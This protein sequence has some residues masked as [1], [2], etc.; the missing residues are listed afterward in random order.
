MWACGSNGG[1]NNNQSNSPL[2]YT[3]KVSPDMNA[4]VVV[5]V[6]EVIE[7][8]IVNVYEIND[9][10]DKINMTES[11]VRIGESITFTAG[12]NV[13]KIKVHIGYAQ[14]FDWVE[15]WIPIT[16]ILQPNQP[17]EILIKNFM[18]LS[19]SEP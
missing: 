2:Q 14:G 15:G 9:D 7:G 16:Y 18:T 12:Q 17:R 8:V 11:V 5:P 6:A 10:N 4:Y 13:S 19:R 1:N 3:V